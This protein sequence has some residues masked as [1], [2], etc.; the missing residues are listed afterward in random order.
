MCIAIN[1]STR[2]AMI[3]AMAASVRGSKAVLAIP[4]S[5]RRL[6]PEAS[7]RM[8]STPWPMSA[9]TPVKKR[10]TPSAMRS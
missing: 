2:K 4:A 1:R 7:A 6:R 10:C 9:A 3:V 5:M 8:S